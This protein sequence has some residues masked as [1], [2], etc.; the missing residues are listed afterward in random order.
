RPARDA[1][2]SLP[3][4]APSKTSFARERRRRERKHR[5]SSIGSAA[6]WASSVACEPVRMS[7]RA[8][9]TVLRTIA[10]AV[11]GLFAAILIAVSL[12]ARFKLIGLFSIA[13]A[14]VIGWGF[15]RLVATAGLSRKSWLVLLA[16][17]VVSV[18]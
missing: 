4:R 14:G 12:P 2:N 15:G 6:R 7:S 17:L 5:R 13:F 16:A 8:G 18:G 3:T 10:I 11:A 9:M 1:R